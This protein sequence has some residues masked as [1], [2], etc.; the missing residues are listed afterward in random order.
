[1]YSKNVVAGFYETLFTLEALKKEVKITLRISPKN[2]LILAKVVELG[3]AN[4]SANEADGL[5]TVVNDKSLEEIKT[6]CME[7][8]SNC[9]LTDTYER[10][11]N[12]QNK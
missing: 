11:N 6:I 3:L 4:K 7:L 1:M 9:G 10:L 8:L 5:F 12:L 2:V